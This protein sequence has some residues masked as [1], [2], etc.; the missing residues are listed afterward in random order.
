[1]KWE[2][3]R[4]RGNK[5]KRGED[6]RFSNKSW[7]GRGILLCLMH[8]ILI[9]AKGSP[10]MCIR[11]L[12]NTN[13][14]SPNRTRVLHPRSLA[15]DSGLVLK[16]PLLELSARHRDRTFGSG[17]HEHGKDHQPDGP[18]RHHLSRTRLFAERRSN[19]A[20]CTIC[21]PL[22]RAEER[23]ITFNNI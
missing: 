17:Y 19:S 12:T 4:K 7:T 13:V 16:V 6:R 2:E 3:K 5:K 9:F 15:L 8:V 22:I 18:S 1:M 10:R 14:F 20:S 23:R 11:S 21:A